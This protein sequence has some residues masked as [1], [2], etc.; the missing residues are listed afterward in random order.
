MKT[1]LDTRMIIKRNKNYLFIGFLLFF[2][3]GMI[4]TLIFNINLGFGIIYTGLFFHIL[5]KLNIIELGIK[6]E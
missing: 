5:E 1:R 4:L 2:I 3:I 6:N